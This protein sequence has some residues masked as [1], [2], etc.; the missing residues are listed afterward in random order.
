MIKKSNI[1]QS[2]PKKI[3]PIKGNRRTSRGEK[4]FLDT[5]YYKSIV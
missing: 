5:Q 3:T 4:I 1:P 2:R